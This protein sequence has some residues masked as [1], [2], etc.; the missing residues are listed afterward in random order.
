MYLRLTRLR[1]RR[2]PDGLEAEKPWG[3]NGTVKLA[4]V[5]QVPVLTGPPRKKKQPPTP[6]PGFPGKLVGTLAAAG[7]GGL[8]AAYG[9]A[10]D[11]HAADL[12]SA[13]D[14]WQQ[15][16]APHETMKGRYQDVFSVAANTAPFGVEAG[17][18][19]TAARSSPTL[20]GAM[21][22]KDHLVKSVGDW[23]EGVTHSVPA[24]P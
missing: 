24:W 16:L 11:T 4:A 17:T 3:E 18:L 7:A 9:M 13:L 14:R 6:P 1:T 21:G 19:L 5:P 2:A 12:R 20:M 15:P 8:G 22:Q 10:S 23:H